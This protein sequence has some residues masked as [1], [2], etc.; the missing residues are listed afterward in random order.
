M[1]LVLVSTARRRKDI[2]IPLWLSTF[3]SENFNIVSNDHG[4]T[5]KCDFSILDKKYAFWE[6]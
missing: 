4:N 6:I 2:K 5:Q 3:R 1:A